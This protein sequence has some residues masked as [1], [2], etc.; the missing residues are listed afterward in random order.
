MERTII[1]SLPNPSFLSVDDEAPVLIVHQCMVK[2]F[3]GV[4]GISNYYHGTKL[5]I[6]SDVYDAIEY[7]KRLQSTD[8]SI[9]QGI[10]QMPSQIKLSFEEEILEA[11]RMTIS[12]ISYCTEP[13]TVSILA[14]VIEI[15]Y[16]NGW[17]YNSCFKCL[18]K[19]EDVG[20]KFYC[21]KCSKMVKSIKR[22]KVNVYAIDDSGSASLVLFDGSLLP[23]IGK[24]AEE[25]QAAID[26]AAHGQGYP[27]ELNSMIGE[28]FMLNI[29]V[30][31]KNIEDNW[32]TYTVRKLS[33]DQAIIFKYRLKHNIEDVQNKNCNAT[34][35]AHDDQDCTP[36]VNDPGASTEVRGKRDY[37][38][39]DLASQDEGERLQASAVKKK[40]KM[41]TVKV[42]PNSN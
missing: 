2:T 39:A 31:Q 21:S 38:V 4:V 34:Q 26:E 30:T 9:S 18:K 3:G 28:F 15:N 33:H 29:D 7:K 36:R 32:Q 5:L 35:S 14:K 10:T 6:N 22:Y 1:E 19:V 41:A 16:D 25:L 11:P 17:M 40:L 27:I 23:F 20:N 12:D 24:N 42:E 37:D 8:V 13:C